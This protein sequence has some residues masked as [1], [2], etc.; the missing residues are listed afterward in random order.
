MQSDEARQWK[1]AI[2]VELETLRILL[3]L[4]A[5]WNYEI[6]QIDVTTAFLHGD[7]DVVVFM[8]QPE[9]YVQKDKEDFV[10]MLLKSLYGLKQAP[11]VWFRLLK[12]FLERELYTLMKCETCVAVKVID[13]LLV[14]ISIYGDDLILFARTKAMMRDMKQMLFKRFVMKDLDLIHYILGWEI[15]RNRQARTIFIKPKKYAKKV[16]QH[17]AMDECNGCKVPSDPSLRLSKAM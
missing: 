13:G 11:R 5:I 3:T 14:F 6:D 16:L 15:T 2:D 12:K 9:G 10:C 4:A 1:D 7:I 8:E 17:F